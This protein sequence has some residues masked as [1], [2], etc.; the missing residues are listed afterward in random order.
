MES[1]SNP[2]QACKILLLKPNSVFAAVKDKH[3]W[4]WIP[5]LLVAVTSVLPSLLYFNMIDMQWYQDT[6]IASVQGDMSPAERR[7]LEQSFDQSS[8]A[9]YTVLGG[10]AGLLIANAVLALYLHFATKHD[11]QLVWGF[12]DWYGFGWWLALPTAVTSLLAAV[13]ILVF[14]GAETSPTIMAPTS[15]AFLL[16]IEMNSA[17]LILLQTIRLESFWMMYL[18]VIGLMHWTNTRYNNAVMIAVTPYAILWVIM[19]LVF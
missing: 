1:I 9:S 16:N 11:E 7:M 8:L 12:T 19:A 3:N 13:I 5:F 15:L 14:S 4:A 2:L 10:I 17:Y 6:I 18:T